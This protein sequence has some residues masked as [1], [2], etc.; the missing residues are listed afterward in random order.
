MRETADPAVQLDQAFRTL[1]VTGS[2]PEEIAVDR[3][4]FANRSNI[5]PGSRPSAGDVGDF[6]GM[7]KPLRPDSGGGVRDRIANRPGGNDGIRD[8]I[9]N[10][11][12]DGD[13][14]RDRIGDRRGDDGLR[15]RV[16]DRVGDRNNI[17]DRIGGRDVNIGEINVGNNVINNRPTWANIDRSRVNNINNRWGNQIGGL[18]SWNNRHP[19]RR[20]YWHGWADGVRS[21][22]YHH[23][24]G[25]FGYGWWNRHP[26]GWCGWHYG[27][28]FRRYP[29]RYWWTVPTFVACTNFFAWSAPTQVWT[30]PIYYDYGQGGNVVYQDNS[31]YID[32]TAVATA[33]EFAQSAATLATVTP[34]AD[35]SELEDMEWLALGTFAITKDPKDVDPI[36]AVQLAVNQQGVI[37]GTV[38]NSETDEAYTVQGQVDQ[39]TQRVAMRVGESDSLVV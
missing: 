38:F 28:S 18:H 26:H 36:S 4:D 12:G 7:D 21:R 9:G 31:V 35:E 2:V 27:Y 25:C 24:H 10:R 20:G 16:G 23:F 8:R 37:S 13:G 33:E 14:V 34:P 39:Q 6:L 19:G 29:A 11:G 15:D 5:R 17:G 32:G 30:Q 1:V 22:G 3:P